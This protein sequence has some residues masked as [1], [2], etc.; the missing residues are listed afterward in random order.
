MENVE[1]VAL[2]PLMIPAGLVDKG[3]VFLTT[4][5][6]AN[7]LKTMGFAEDAKKPSKAHKKAD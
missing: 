7:E 1:L 5:S 6:H 4:P 2:R 3:E